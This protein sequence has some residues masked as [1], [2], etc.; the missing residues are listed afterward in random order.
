MK[1]LIIY[2][3]LTQQ[4]T[5]WLIVFW[6]FCRQRKLILHSWDSTER[7]RFETMACS[8]PQQ[9]YWLAGCGVGTLLFALIISLLWPTI[10]YKYLLYPQLVLKEGSV[11]YD[12]WI[13]TPIP[14]YLEIFMFNWTNPEE[15]HNLSTKPHFTEMGPYVFEWVTQCSITYNPRSTCLFLAKNISEPT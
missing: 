12:N 15:V 8:I 11:N 2:Q 1:I 3:L 10:A 14:I 4:I 5:D 6:S 7:H 9:K 13:E